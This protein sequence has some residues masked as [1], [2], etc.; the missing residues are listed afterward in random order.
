MS[1]TYAVKNGSR[2][3]RQNTRDAIVAREAFRT[4]GALRGEWNTDLYEVYSYN[5]VIAWWDEKHGWTVNTHRYSVT[6]GIHRGVVLEALNSAK[7]AYTT[8]EWIW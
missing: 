4:G 1:K 2:E 6:S 7:V 5:A 8:D 3:S